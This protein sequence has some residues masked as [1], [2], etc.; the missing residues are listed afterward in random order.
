[1]NL[2]KGLLVASLSSLLN[3]GVS[4]QDY[5]VDSEMEHLA[6]NY[7]IYQNAENE[8]LRLNAVRDEALRVAKKG[9]LE[10]FSELATL[11][12]MYGDFSGNY[13]FEKNSKVEDPLGET[14]S[15]VRDS[16]NAFVK[17]LNDLIYPGKAKFSVLDGELTLK[18]PFDLEGNYLTT[19]MS[20]DEFYFNVKFNRPGF[21]DDFVEGTE[22]FLTLA[23]SGLFDLM[24]SPVQL[25]GQR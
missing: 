4:A 11:H 9:E 5:S 13:D 3:V 2:K 17:S 24:T 25:I 21:S 6:R 22:E 19:R 15:S 18:F 16:Q 8:R 1:M 10:R 14:I 7:I 12:F 20:P 23:P